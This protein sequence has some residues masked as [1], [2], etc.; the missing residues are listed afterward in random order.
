MLKRVLTFN[1]AN[2]SYNR[3]SLMGF[4]IIWI[5]F[6]H[7]VDRIN[8][9]IVHEF[10]QFGWGGVDLFFLVSGFGLAHSLSKNPPVVLFYKK[11]AIR[12]VPTWWAIMLLFAIVSLFCGL[13]VTPKW[14]QVFLKYSGIGWWL[15]GCFPCLQPMLIYHEWYIP[16]LLLFYL[17]AP[18][19]YRIPTKGLLGITLLLM[20][21]GVLF[22]V[23]HFLD[24]IYIS[25]SRIPVF[26]LGFF[27]YQLFTSQCVITWRK[28][29]VIFF[30]GVCLMLIGILLRDINQ[31]LSLNIRRYAFM[32]IL[33][34]VINIIGVAT[35][36]IAPLKVGL[37]F[38]GTLSLEIY[39]LHISNPFI[40]KAIDGLNRIFPECLSQ[41]IVF[42][43][44][45][46]I[47]WVFHNIMDKFVNRF[48]IFRH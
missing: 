8:I 20:L 40:V 42:S 5:F 44:I 35:E 23:F 22:P 14:W 10:F 28:I 19:I 2:I 7:L 36:R 38:L 17:F 34:V 37:S 21:C 25:Y 1:P 13:Y 45:V 30:V 27:A 41:I 47:A 9:P 15:H 26:I 33:P 3:S 16:T 48:V 29:G 4:A 24:S 39:L 46:G 32:M 6:Y 18:L 43:V 12:I 31:V 11:R